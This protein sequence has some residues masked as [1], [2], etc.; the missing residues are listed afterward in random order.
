VSVFVAPASIRMRAVS[1]AKATAG[2]IAN[3]ASAGGDRLSIGK[4]AMIERAPKKGALFRS[5]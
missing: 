2:G 5:N 3:S 4:F 1:V